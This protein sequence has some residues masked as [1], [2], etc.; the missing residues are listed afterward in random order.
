MQNISFYQKDEIAWHEQLLIHAR[1]SLLTGVLVASFFYS[2]VIC[3]LMVLSGNTDVML[4]WIIASPAILMLS[5]YL[6]V[7]HFSLHPNILQYTI[8]LSLSTAEAY[9]SA[10]LFV[11]NQTFIAISQFPVFITFALVGLWHYKHSLISLAYIFIIHCSLFML[12]TDYSFI[13]WFSRWAILFP[14]AFGMLGLIKFRYD[15][16]RKNFML[17]Q[18][19]KRSK[20]ALEDK[21]ADITASINYALRIQR[22]ILPTAE[23][24]H[25]LLPNS[26]VFYKPKDIVSGDFYFLEH[27]QDRLILAVADCTGHGVPGAFLSM[28]GINLLTQ[29]TETTTAPHLILEELNKGIEKTLKQSQNKV[30]DGMDIGIV[31]LQKKRSGEDFSSDYMASLEFAGAINSFYAV[32]TNKKDNTFKEFIEIKGDKQAIGGGLYTAKHGISKTFTAHTISWDSETENLNFFLCS[33]GYQD[34]FG[35]TENRKFMTKNLKLLFQR[36]AGLPTQQQADEIAS[37]FDS[38]KNGQTQL[39]DVLVIGVRL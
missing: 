8:L 24:I 37:I 31:S 32:K 9:Q 30:R 2:G 17:N 22:A 23:T 12:F 1:G 21:N 4:F 16:T 38:W 36:I 11:P 35:G 13:S 34:Q 28:L 19:I 6:V 10:Y 5:C 29:I 18:E 20:V 7:N 33:D 25:D 27:R 14:V 26:F 39:D 15:T 3:L